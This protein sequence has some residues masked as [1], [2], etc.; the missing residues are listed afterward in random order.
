M[1]P[2]AT[3]PQHNLKLGTFW[4]LLS[5]VGYS[6]NTLVIGRLTGGTVHV[7]PWTAMMLRGVIGLITV[8]VLAPGVLRAGWKKLFTQRLMLERGFIGSLGIVGLYYTLAPLGPG[9]ATLI[10]NSW[11]VFASL[12]ATVMLKEQLG[13]VRMLG[14]LVT[15]SG[16]ALLLGVG[17]DLFTT[18]SFYEWL[19][20]L[21]A[22]FSAIA[23]I[24]I[25][26]LS[27]TE[28]SALIFASQCVYC[29]LIGLP[30]S[31]AELPL[32]T[33]SQWS[34]LTVAAIAVSLAQLAMTEG[35]RYLTVAAGG[36]FQMGLPLVIATL[37]VI[38]LGETFSATQLM[39][40]A[41]ILVGS[42]ITVLNRR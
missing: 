2:L 36:T 33:G 25:R 4:M 3:P 7:G 22:F 38:W 9:K 8:Q 5:L 26:Q 16:L 41:C 42:L 11:A 24:A 1:T 6:F 35:F 40:A 37:S 23:V 31:L 15:F 32:M 28:T 21:G 17:W 19:A 29:F 13:W 30:L 10:N 18:V 27:A 20:L 14:L 34:W 12:M 39:G